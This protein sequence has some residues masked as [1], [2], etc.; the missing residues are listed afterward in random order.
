MRF[1]RLVA[2]LLTIAAI[3]VAC[4]GSPSASTGGPSTAGQNSPAAGTSE[5]AASTGGGDGG[6]G[7]AN[8]SITYE[9]TGGYQLSGEV[10]FQPLAGGFHPETGGWA[11]VFLDRGSGVTIT[12]NLGRVGQSISVVDGTKA[13]I[14]G[15]S[16]ASGGTGCT[17]TIIKNDPAGLAGHVECS[18]AHVSQDSGDGQAVLTAEWDAHP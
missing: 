1:L 17:F 4:N 7:G 12:L 2:V 3:S 8:G 10:P 13:V 18:T 9:I 11:A 14:S 6:A 5:P 16:S 15:D